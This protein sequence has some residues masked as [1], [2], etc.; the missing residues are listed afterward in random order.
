LEKDRE[1]RLTK[2][3]ILR[4]GIELV[5]HCNLQCIGCDHFSPCAKESYLDI[6]SFERDCAR[7][8]L[9][10]N[11]KLEELWFTGGEPLLHPRC[12]EIFKIARKYFDAQL[13][14]VVTNGILL[15]KQNEEFWNSCRENNIRIDITPYP[16]KLNM[17]EIMNLAHKFGVVVQSFGSGEK[18]TMR[19]YPLDLYGKQD[20]KDSFKMCHLSNECIYLRDGKL[21]TCCIIQGISVFNAHFNTNLNVSEKDYIDIYKAK[22]IDEILEFLCQPVPFCRYCKSRKMVFGIKWRK[23]NKNI[24]EWT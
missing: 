15:C 4:F 14:R 16:I 13:I 21:Y 22:D 6:D 12:N 2:R 17:A 11:R 8:S 9:L 20:F 3:T 7:L 24:S 23:S 5:S 18:L 1:R 19:K 10:T